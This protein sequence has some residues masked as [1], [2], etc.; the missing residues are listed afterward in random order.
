MVAGN[1]SAEAAHA[2]R[3]AIPLMKE[4]A[5]TLVTVGK[6][7][8]GFPATDALSY[9]SRHDVHA[10]LEIVERGVA[11]VEERLEKE[12]PALGAGLIVMGAFGGSRDRKIVGEGQ[13]VAGRVDS[14]GSND[15]KKKKKKET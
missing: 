13:R 14:G 5:V 11:T 6:D 4:R 7:E 12:A 3:A 8:D 1:G 9:L 15:N 2:L 10:E